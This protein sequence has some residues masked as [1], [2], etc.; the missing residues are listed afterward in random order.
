MSGVLK[1]NP[2]MADV[3][4]AAQVHQTTVSLALR[5]HPSIPEAT[6]ARIAEIARGLGYRRN[7]YVSALMSSRRTGAGGK[8]ARLGF[9][10]VCE[11]R[12]QWREESPNYARLFDLM[13]ARAAALGYG[14]EE[15]WY[16]EPGV[17]P[18]RLRQILLHRGVRGVILCPLPGKQ[19]EL[20]FDFTDF[21]VVALRYTLRKPALDHV[22]IDYGAAMD[23]A[24]NHLLATGH[25]RLAFAS[26]TETDERVNHLSLGAY[27]ARRHL[28]PR[29]FLAPQIEARWT[30]ELFLRSLASLRPDALMVPGYRQYCRFAEWLKA[31]G[32]RL[33]EDLSLVTLD[34]RIGTDEAGVVQNLEGE[35]TAAVDLVTSR[36]ERAQFGIPSRSQVVLVEGNWRDGTLFQKRSRAH[37]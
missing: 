20:G 18:A 13:A 23:L 1:P 10:T 8:G 5:N 33:P 34:C 28:A 9:L 30:S 32:K 6:R 3:A 14:L 22:S 21:A 29:R 17:S 24:I 11:H 27:L 7:P 37:Q 4:R 15:F 25:Q 26:T 31:A 12:G 19:H 35:A 36:V 16:N 2:T